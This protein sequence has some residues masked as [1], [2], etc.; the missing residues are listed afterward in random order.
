MIYYIDFFLLPPG[1]YTTQ[2][3]ET[4]LQQAPGLRKIRHVEFDGDDISIFIHSKR[5]LTS[6]AV[7]AYTA[8][9][10]DKME[11]SGD[12]PD[13]VCFTSWL[14]PLVTGMVKE[15]LLAGKFDEQVFRAVSR[16]QREIAQ[17]S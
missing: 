13:W 14:G 11:R 17:H 8:W 3:K 9:L 15:G 4:L 6:C 10:Q 12:S 7:N 5:K 16:I 2:E 1:G